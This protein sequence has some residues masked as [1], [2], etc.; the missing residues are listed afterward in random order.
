MLKVTANAAIRTIARAPKGVL[1]YV[2][3]S[4]LALLGSSCAAE[5]PTSTVSGGTGGTAGS[6]GASAGTAGASAGTAGTTGGAAGTAGAG[7]GSAGTPPACDFA[8]VIQKS[9]AL[10][11]CHDTM[12]KQGE[13]DFRTPGYEQRLVNAPATFTDITCP[14]P[15]GGPLPVACTPP[16]CAPGT[17]LINTAAPAESWMLK[18]LN[19]THNECGDPMPLAPGMVTPDEKACLESWIH[20]LAGG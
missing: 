4:T 11:A 10:T 8:G 20:Y 12:Y 18:K 16:S 6:A 15:A 19:G 9:C 5:A 14:D 2:G 7:G 3:A 17:L 13:L 1:L